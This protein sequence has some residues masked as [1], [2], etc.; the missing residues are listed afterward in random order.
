MYLEIA[1]FFIVGDIEAIH[2]ISGKRVSIEVK[3]DSRIAETRNV[4]CEE[5][6]Y[7]KQH[8]YY[9]R[10]N[11]YSNTDVFCVVS[12][13]ERKIYVLDFKSLKANYRRGIY[14]EIE[15]PKQTTFCYL[16]NLDDLKC[17]GAMIAEIEF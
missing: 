14:K 9:G 12:I 6:V 11:M 4:L 15:H 2:K 16:C 10:G 1:T 5:E 13:P 17:W 8:D 3:N 7:Y